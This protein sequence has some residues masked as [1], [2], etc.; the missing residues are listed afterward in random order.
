MVHP[1]FRVIDDCCVRF[2][3]IHIDSRLGDGGMKEEDVP[4][5]IGYSGPDIWRLQT[6]SL[7]MAQLGRMMYKMHKNVLKNVDLFVK[8]Y[9]QF[10]RV[11]TFDILVELARM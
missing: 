8:L 7:I 11:A 4:N 5:L 3:F 9:Q 10:K 1:G 2:P 6:I